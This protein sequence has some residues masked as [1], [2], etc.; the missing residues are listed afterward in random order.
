[1]R[2]LIYVYVLDCWNFLGLS[3][4]QGANSQRS[5]KSLRS[6]HGEAQQDISIMF[7]V[8]PELHN[9]NDF[10]RPLEILLVHSATRH[11]QPQCSK[12]ETAKK[13]PSRDSLRKLFA[14]EA[15]LYVFHQSRPPK[16]NKLNKILTI[17]PQS[18]L[19]GFLDLEDLC[20]RCMS[21]NWP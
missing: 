10:H 8:N 6:S 5:H 15:L 4:R 7:R 21:V 3:C 14:K 1:M 9:I 18:F 13:D 19:T 11:S 17:R 16:I 2:I 20:A 12:N